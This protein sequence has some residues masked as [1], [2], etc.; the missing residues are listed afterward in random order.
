LCDFALSTK[1]RVLSHAKHKN[2]H[3]AK[4]TKILSFFAQS[5][6][7]SITSK[8]IFITTQNPFLQHINFS[9]LFPHQTTPRAKKRQGKKATG[10]EF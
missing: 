5:N 6:P 8:T 4:K 2:S 9:S 7:F 3:S 1:L 10:R